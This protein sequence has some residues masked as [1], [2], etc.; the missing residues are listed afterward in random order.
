M[1]YVLLVEKHGLWTIHSQGD[2]FEKLAD[3]QN[4]LGKKN[5]KAR[6]I[7]MLRL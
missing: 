6:L 3:M 7:N 2:D 5:K 4:E 1:Q